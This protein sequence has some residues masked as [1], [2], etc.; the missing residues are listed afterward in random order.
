LNRKS[1][2]RSN[3]ESVG[4]EGEVTD[5]ESSFVGNNNVGSNEVASPDE[6]W[7]HPEANKANSKF[8]TSFR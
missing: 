7:V 5:V 1:S 6:D 2:T 3:N 8:K 4:V